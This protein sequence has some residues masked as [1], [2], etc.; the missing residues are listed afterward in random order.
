MTSLRGWVLW[1]VLAVSLIGASL[2]ATSTGHPS[3]G[4]FLAVLAICVAVRNF[5]SSWP[6]RG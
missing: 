4:G 2:L 1:R 3:I 6:R 5:L